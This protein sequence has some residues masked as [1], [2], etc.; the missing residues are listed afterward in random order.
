MIR[1]LSA[2]TLATVSH[3]RHEVVLPPTGWSQQSIGIVHFGIGAFH[4]AH[5]ALYTQEAFAS[6]GDDRWGISGVTQRTAE[7]QRQLALQ[8]GLYG[9]LDGSLD[10]PRLTVVGGVREVLYPV[11]QFTELTQRISSPEVTIITLTI[12]EKGYRRSST[13]GLDVEDPA[14]AEDLRGG[15]PATAVGR[16]VRGLAARADAGGGP[17]TVLSCDNL[18]TNGR[19]LERL[20]LEFCAAS[21][22]DDLARWI[23]G[24]VT[25]PSSMVD[26]IVPATTERD[27]ERASAILG[28]SDRGLV[29]AETFRQWVI[30]DRFAADRPR[31]EVGGAQVVDDVEPFEQMKLRILNGTHSALAYRGAL[32]GYATI[33]EAVADPELRAFAEEMIATDIIPVTPPPPG[34]DREVYAATVI[35]RFA[36]P[37][38]AHTTRQVAMDGSQKIPLRLL[39]TLRSNLDAG[40]M[41]W[42]VVLA[43]GAWMSYVACAQSDAHRLRIE[44]P[45]AVQL[46]DRVRGVTNPAEIVDSLLDMPSV[47]GADLPA[48]REL[49]DALIDAVRQEF[50]RCVR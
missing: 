36:D 1:S 29:V 30:E 19:V 27:R 16:L 35:E 43:V 10:H 40:R 28:L 25:F 18:T 50:A 11:E 32:R 5:Q 24:N 45:L 12:T 4:R 42:G 7:V 41:P 26:R 8:D 20:V 21:G 44:D 33:A 6:T 17:I 38:L 9:V 23:A 49:R 13:G 22:Q 46:A 2:E 31:W 14:V 39:G 34:Q 37:S 3:G 15:S 48:R 47:F